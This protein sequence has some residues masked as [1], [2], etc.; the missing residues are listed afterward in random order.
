ME[1]NHKNDDQQME[2]KNKPKES[3]DES[4][5]KYVEDG[6]ISSSRRQH[7]FGADISWH[8]QYSPPPE[9]DKM[10]S[11]ISGQTPWAEVPEQPFADSFTMPF[12]WETIHL[13]SNNEKELQK[14]IKE[15]EDRVAKQ[16]NEILAAEA[17][18]KEKGITQA[19][20]MQENEQFKKKTNEYYETRSELGKE[21]RYQFLLYH[22]KEEARQHLQKSGELFNQFENTQSCNTVVISIDIRRSTELMLLARTPQ[23]YVEFI[24]NVCTDLIKIIKDNFGVF[25][26][27]TGDGILAFFPDFYSG[28]D[29]VY[30]AI[31]SASECHKCFSNHYI[32]NRDRFIAIQQEIGLGI[33]IDCDNTPLVKMQDAYTVIGNAVV[34]ACRMSGVDAGNTLLNQ[35]AYELVV[36][37]YSEYLN[38]TESAIKIKTGETLVGHKVI[39]L[40]KL[41]TP[42]L[43]NWIK[44]ENR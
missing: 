3:P 10:W 8:D 15:L 7:G 16:H 19:Q 4:N 9:F 22:V 34:Y 13:P 35:R 18:L 24:M 37:R 23:G 40:E 26:K 31:K 41:F 42:K 17:I 20:S 11:P 28:Q 39:L 30:Y 32:N 38:C 14:R 33:G 43:P 44:M 36:D 29:A 12:M 25:D 27:F 5:N 1:K 2:E 21:K 6:L